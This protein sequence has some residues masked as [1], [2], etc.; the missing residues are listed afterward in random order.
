VP[1]T[2]SPSPHATL[3]PSHSASGSPR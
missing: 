1:A 2:P 3:T